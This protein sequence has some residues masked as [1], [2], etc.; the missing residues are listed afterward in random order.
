MG[1]TGP[2]GGT[3]FYVDMARPAGSQYFEVACAGWSDGVC[4]GDDLADPQ[5]E[6]GCSETLIPGADGIA[7]GTGEQNTT[8]IANGCTDAGIAG[9]LAHDLTL[10]GQTEWFLPTQDELN[11]LCK[12]AYN[13][14]T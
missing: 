1:D 2:G 6:W 4:G 13:D 5:A 10:G 9:K 3:I 14:E 8:D 12:W 11:A 7:I